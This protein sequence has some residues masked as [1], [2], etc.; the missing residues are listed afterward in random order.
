MSEI[1]LEIDG[2][3]TIAAHR[4]WLGLSPYL[5]TVTTPNLFQYAVVST[6]PVL[7]F[8]RSLP[9]GKMATVILAKAKDAVPG[10][11]LTTNANGNILSRRIDAPSLGL[12]PLALRKLSPWDPK[13][14][15]TRPKPAYEMEQIIPGEDP[16]DHHS[17]PII[18]A[19][20]LAASGDKGS[21]RTVLNNLCAQ[22]LRCLD[23]HAHLG[24]IAFAGKTKAA[25]ELSLRH[26]EVGVR[27]GE[28]SL[29]DNFDGFLLWG[30]ID[31]RPFH[32][33]LVGYGLSLWR[34]K[35]F[36]EA[37]Q[38][39]ERML[40]LNPPDNLGAREMLDDARARQPWRDR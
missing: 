40:N 5:G 30:T 34:L 39:F 21:A 33:C 3:H 26:Y 17:D 15:K 11:I 32:R 2:A 9:S 6:N 29:G 35:R 1:D 37:A 23:A 27:I 8:C 36:D 16:D 24:I 38:V 14:G 7:A 28:L 31:N 4:K 20:D 10:E 18:E 25:A 13:D 22:D 12:K 19:A